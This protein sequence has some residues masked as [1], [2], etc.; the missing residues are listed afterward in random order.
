MRE[1]FIG[2]SA[3]PKAEESLL[4]EAG[5]GWIK[6]GFPVPYEGKIGGKITAE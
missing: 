3:Y 5:I 1:L 6:Q 4:K 2:T